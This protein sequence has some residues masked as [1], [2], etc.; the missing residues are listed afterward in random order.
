M[1]NSAKNANLWNRCYGTVI[2]DA[3]IKLR[4]LQMV[5]SG[6]VPP[7]LIYDQYSTTNIF[8]NIRYNKQIP[9]EVLV[10]SDALKTSID[11]F[12]SKCC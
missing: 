11:S 1:V 6:D 10:L 3:T 4:W 5:K 8:Y 12:L 2:R 7:H 9:D